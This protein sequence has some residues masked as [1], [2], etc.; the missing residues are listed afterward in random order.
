MA[1]ATPAPAADATAVNGFDLSTLSAVDAS[2]DLIKATRPRASK[3]ADSPLRKDVLASYND[4]K[5]MEYANVP[6]DAAENVVKELRGC[7]RTIQTTDDAGNVTGTGIGLK[8]KVVPNDDGNTSAVVFQGKEL[9]K[10]APKAAAPTDAPAE[11]A[12]A[13]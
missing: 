6:N 7:A 5:V 2:P 13:A 4:G 1:K 9:A 12:P 8:V 10:H 3:Y 11:D